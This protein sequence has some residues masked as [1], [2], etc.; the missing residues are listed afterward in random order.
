MDLSD[1]RKDYNLDTLEISDANPNAID[2]F[3]HWMEIALKSDEIEPNA[4]IFSTV[5]SE[6]NPDARTILLKGVEDEKLA[7]YT[8][9]NSTKGQQLVDN[10]SG[11]LLFL[12]LTL[13]RQVRVKG[14]VVKMTKEQAQGYF[15]SRP[16]G[17]QIGAWSSPQSEVI[18]NREILEKQVVYYDK[19]FEGVDQ[20]PIPEFWGGYY[21]IP[22]E[23]EFWQGRTSRLHDRLRYTL[24]ADGK[25]WKIERLAP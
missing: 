13:H 20:I 14:K 19:K 22:H 3:K 24:E 1:L 5:D 9:Y 7:F 6:N 11:H 4:V 10:Q 23:I 8:N 21:L 12:W 18:P 16:R 15:S 2:Q 17:S 25:T